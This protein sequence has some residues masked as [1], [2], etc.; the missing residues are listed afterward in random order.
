M[1][2]QR[3]NLDAVARTNLED[4]P[5]RTA[6]IAPM[7]IRRTDREAM[8]G[9][10]V[11]PAP[12]SRQ[13]AGSLAN[14][15]ALLELAVRERTER[16]AALRR[17]AAFG[18]PVGL[19]AAKG[20]GRDSE[21]FLEQPVEIGGV[22]EAAAVA[23]V[24]DG[25]VNVAG[26]DQ[27]GAGALQAPLAQIVAE[28]D[29]VLLEQFLQIA[30]RNSLAPGYAG[31]GQVR[32]MQAPFDRSVTRLKSA[33]R[34]DVAAAPAPSCPATMV[35]NRVRDAL[36]ERP[37]FGRR[38]RVHLGGGGLHEFDE[39]AR[40]P[41]GLKPARRGERPPSRAASIETAV[42]QRHDDDG[43]DAIERNA[44]FLIGRQQNEGS[45][46]DP[47]GTARSPRPRCRLR[48]AR[49]R[50]EGGTVGSAARAS[51]NRL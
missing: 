16:P 20:A 23:D 21:P 42:R 29:A 30:L 31:S 6:E 32:I 34:L 43:N 35:K 33:T 14:R 4:R 49:D 24:G 1:L 38:Q 37:P 27:G 19:L 39:H 3:F 17:A 36:L 10:F 22:A 28:A 45:G 40:K 50:S 15:A 41:L 13:A 48:E 2:G 9:A 8:A 11:P 18:Q 26:R 25:S 51:A 5:Q 46:R 12:R 7:H 47:H 44:P